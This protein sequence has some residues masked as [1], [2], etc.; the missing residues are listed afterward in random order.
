MYHAYCVL[1]R[2]HATAL[3]TS[4]ASLDM[5]VEIQLQEAGRATPAVR[6]PHSM[7]LAPR[8]SGSPSRAERNR[9]LHCVRLSAM[10][11]HALVTPNADS[12]TEHDGRST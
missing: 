12:T 7:E 6:L 1:L 8:H 5:R 9:V 10:L 2:Q 4:A 11:L 3:R